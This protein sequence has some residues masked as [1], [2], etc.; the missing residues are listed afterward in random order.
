MLRLIKQ[1]FDIRKDEWLK[2][3]MMAAFFF[4]VIFTFWVLK[5]IKRGLLLSYF[6]NNPLNLLGHSFAG[7]QTEQ[8]AK[9]LNLIFAYL[10][11]VVLTTLSHRL[12]RDKI[13]YA[14]CGSILLLLVVYGSVISVPSG[15]VAISF[16]IFGDMFNTVMLTL[17]WAFMNDLVLPDQAKRLYGVIGLGGVV[18]GLLG[19]SLV[20][21]LVN[22]YGRTAM[23]FACLLPVSLIAVITWRVNRN[24]IEQAGLPEDN[25]DTGSNPAVEGARMVF[26][27]PYLL[28]IAGLVGCYEIV[29]NIIDFQLS[30]SVERY[31]SA[32]LERDQFFGL[33]GQIQSSASILIQM[34]L[35][36]FI[37]RRFGVGAA[38]TLLPASIM[39]GSIGFVV[40]PSLAFAAVMSASDN[41]LNYSLNQSAREALYV[42]TSRAQKYRAKA[43]IDMFVQ[44]FA[45]VLSVFINLFL[46]ARVSELRVLS[47]VNLVI[48][49]GW[50]LAV[51]YA[52]RSFDE[53]TLPTDAP[54]TGGRKTGGLLQPTVA[55]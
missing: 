4:L 3:V 42:P 32:S 12:T 35:T 28:S 48:L 46:I 29:S 16:Y 21:T 17:F 55:T 34:F 41:S 43:F 5:P 50:F 30:A 33:L 2:V 7:A 38:L 45:K 37:M 6:S 47:V 54:P 19:S 51:R 26:K 24:A 27:S 1:F 22:D 18:G 20:R 52:G 44:R 14:F 23:V 36:S 9:I 8:L 10:L 31:I 40:T 25:Q 13:I 53:M 11:A 49:V 39:L 15:S